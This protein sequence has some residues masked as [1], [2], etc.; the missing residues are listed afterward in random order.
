[1]ETIDSER[2]KCA[3]YNRIDYDLGKKS[4]KLSAFAG[5]RSSGLAMRSTER[6]LSI[7]LPIGYGSG[8][9]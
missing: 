7:M 4:M 6:R 5:M 9:L 3:V 1:M 2:V 8:R